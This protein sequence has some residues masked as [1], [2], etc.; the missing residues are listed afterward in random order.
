MKIEKVTILKIDSLSNIKPIKGYN[1]D[2]IIINSKLKNDF[3]KSEVRMGVLPMLKP[4]G[5]ILYY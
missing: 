2:Y 1:I 4:D 3:E 5:K